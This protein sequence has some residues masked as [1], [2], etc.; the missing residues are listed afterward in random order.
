MKNDVIIFEILAKIRN[1][2]LDINKIAYRVAA[3][4]QNNIATQQQEKGRA[5]AHEL[6]LKALKDKTEGLRFSEITKATGLSH[7]TVI[8][9][10]KLLRKEG[11]I[12]RIK[13]NG[14]YYRYFLV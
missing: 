2:R 14:L 11:R 5:A 7:T 13:F 6:I 3:L 8:R 1:L 10:L 4:E 9:L 12:K